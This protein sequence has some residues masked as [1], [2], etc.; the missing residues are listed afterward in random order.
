M[1][2]KSAPTILQEELYPPSAPHRREDDARNELPSD[3][4]DARLVDADAAAVDRKPWHVILEVARRTLGKLTHIRS[5]PALNGR[6]ARHVSNTPRYM[7]ARVGWCMV[8]V[9]S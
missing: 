7:S 1:A 6:P 2:R 4:D 5:I 8:T 9:R 3:I